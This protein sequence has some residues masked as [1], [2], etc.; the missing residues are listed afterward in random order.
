M[1][2]MQNLKTVSTCAIVALLFVFVGADAQ[3]RRAAVKPATPAAA[4]SGFR[5]IQIK[6][7]PGATV[8]LDG[9]R[10]GRTKENGEI[11]I[12]TVSTGGHALR[13][14]ADGFREF[15]QTIP[16][17]KRGQVIA[18][19]TPT[20]DQAEL[21][22]QSAVRLSSLDREA[23]IAEFKK[24]IGHR[25]NFPEAYVEMARLLTETGDIDEAAT[26]IATAR[27][28]RP[29]YAEAT[30]VLGRIYKEDADEPKAIATFKRAISEGKGFQP[31]A[32]TGLGLLYKEKAESDIGSDESEQN[33][34]EA[35]KYFRTALKQLSGAP[36]AAVIY[37]L[38]GLIYERQQKNAEAIAIYEEF[39]SIFP[40]S[41][42]ATAVRSFIVQLKKA[43]E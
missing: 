15:N 33:F 26:A 12:K 18:T 35:S 2:N 30:A 8:W 43:D 40:D 5:T 11:E 38:L 6:S 3:T 23:A 28:L 4:A 16:A 29:G 10:Y 41:S 32:Y 19:L 27:R 37:Q 34:A 20:T 31:E 14:R 9:V 24:A 22:F 25:S 21:T 13:V 42:D 17:A 1:I 7:E 36:D 39:L